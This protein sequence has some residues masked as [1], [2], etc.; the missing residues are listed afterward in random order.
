[1][2][3][4]KLTLEAE[5]KTV[6]DILVAHLSD[7]EFNGFSEE[8][9]ILVA[10]INE[11]DYNQKL[12]ETLGDLKAQ[13]Q[14]S[15]QQELVADQNWNAKWESDYEPVWVDDFCAVR[16]TFHQPI[17]TVKHEIVVTPKMSFGTGHH[18]TTYMMMKQMEKLDFSAKTVFDYGC[19]TGVLAIL[20]Q[21]L[22]ATTLDAIDI[23]KWAYENTLE[24]VAINN[25]GDTIG[26]YCGEIDAAP[27]QKYDV[28]L[29]NINRNVILGTMDRMA[30]RLKDGGVLLTSG[31]LEE[32]IDLVVK[33][34]AEHGLKLVDTMKREKW[35]CL[36]LG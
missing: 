28:V 22:G 19:G 24:N 8:E 35:R 13:Y 1:M 25:C 14:L 2:N 26:V 17:T 36:V 27:A 10:Y 11:E 4:L 15:I 9:G 34:A 6:N 20:A 18:A 5:D 33:A 31:F 23:D 21:K 16:A 3:Y 32:D 7:F 30:A 12:Q 29:A